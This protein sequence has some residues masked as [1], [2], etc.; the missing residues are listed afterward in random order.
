MPKLLNDKPLGW[1]GRVM[2][3]PIQ[4]D[5]YRDL[6]QLITDLRSCRTYRDYS[7]FQE[8]LLEKVLM[9]QEHRRICR[10]VAKRLRECKAVPPTAPA[11]RS[12]GHASD[13]QTWDL[14]IDVCERVDR[15]LRSIADA[16][17]WRVFS[18]DRRVIVALSRND[19]SGQ[20]AGKAGLQ[21]ERDFIAQWSEDENHFVLMH[22]LTTCLRIG[23]ATL[24]KSLGDE[25]EAY[26]YEI[27]TDADRRRSKQLRKK[28]LAEEALRSGGPLPDDPEGRFV[29]LNVP[30]K[31][32]LPMLRDAFDI[33]ADRGVVGMKVPGGRVMFAADLRR[34]YERW[35]EEEFLEQTDRAYK[36]A[37]RRAGILDVGKH[38]FFGSD[39][40]AARSPIH[41][42]WAI[43]PLHPIACANLITDAAVY[44][45]TVSSESLLRALH[46]VGLRAEWVLPAGQETLAP[47]QIVLRAYNSV[48]GVEI[49]ASD[50]QRFLL[51]LVDLQTWAQSVRELLTLNDLSGHPWPYYLDEGKD[52]A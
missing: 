52:W 10:G 22:D 28:K 45:V 33:A 2:N 14:E 19:P 15:Q 37:L 9:V 41:P 17:A 36:A 39:D 4:Q 7:R 31:T 12:D 21:A 38:L 50:M 35:S 25:Y 8:Q 6:V 30:Y 18:Y 47:G 1:A 34:G 20:M 51:E 32:H 23:D 48:R 44:V 26:L 49:K 13:P 42:P 46:T 5:A 16:L 27:K 29:T 11:L 24:F 40:M 3:H 43:Y